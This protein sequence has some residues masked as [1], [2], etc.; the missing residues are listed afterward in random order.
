MSRS[1][2]E[3]WR[4]AVKVALVGTGRQTLSA[5]EL[6]P[7]LA[8]AAALA[9][10]ERA[11]VLPAVAPAGSAPAP[12][13]TLARTATAQTRQLE[14]VLAGDPALLPEWLARCAAAGRRV[15]EQ[16]LPELLDYGRADPELR[17]ALLA[18]L[19][20]RGRWLATRE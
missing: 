8:E 16:L 13:E 5:P 12:D 3:R 19:G 2:R 11:G 4:E 18:V 1:M 15:D 10:A 7:F 20:A 17:P 6:E 9:V 14:L